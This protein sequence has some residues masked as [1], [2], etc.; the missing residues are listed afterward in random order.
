VRAACTIEVADSLGRVESQTITGIHGAAY[1]AHDVVG[2]VTDAQNKGELALFGT[3]EIQFANEHDAERVYAFAYDH[4]P[5]RVEVTTGV[6]QPRVVTALLFG[7]LLAYVV[8][9]RFAWSAI[10][11]RGAA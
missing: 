9:S 4:D 3:R 8:V 7:A 5:E 11:R 10:L 6:A 2:V 1:R